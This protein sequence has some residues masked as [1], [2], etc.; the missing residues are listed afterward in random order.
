M[1]S[2]IVICKESESLFQNLNEVLMIESLY[3]IIHVA[4]L[5]LYLN[6]LSSLSYIFEQYIF[7]TMVLDVI[8]VKFFKELYILKEHKA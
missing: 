3:G 7:L 8:F 5:E 6:L 4:I 1:V 2:Q